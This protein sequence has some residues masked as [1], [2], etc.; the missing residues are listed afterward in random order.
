MNIFLT[1]GYIA[2]V[3]DEDYEEIS[4][5]KWYVRTSRTKTKNRVMTVYAGRHTRMA[6]GSEKMVYMHRAIMNPKPDE[7]IDHINHFTLD[8]RKENLRI[9]TQTQNQGNRII[10]S[11][12]KSGYKGVSKNGNKWAVYIGSK[13]TRQYLGKFTS[14]KKAAL[15]Y[16]A[17]AIA[18]YG[19]FAKL[20]FPV[21]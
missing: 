14:K 15:A 18:M 9:A 20:N 12:N 16:D 10:Q 7:H 4:K 8:N 21:K 17:A 1:K 19:E 5:H 3:D 11:N 13:K 2:L 6:D